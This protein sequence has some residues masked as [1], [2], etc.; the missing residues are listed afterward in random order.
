MFSKIRGLLVTWVLV[1]SVG[2]VQAGVIYSYDDGSAE[3][4]LAAGV[5]NSSIW[6]NAFTQESLKN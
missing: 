1:C 5:G 3:S 6:L 4:S 2:Q